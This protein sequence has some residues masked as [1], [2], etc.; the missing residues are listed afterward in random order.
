MTGCFEENRLQ[1]SNG[2]IYARDDVSFV[3][4]GPSRQMIRGRFFHISQ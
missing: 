3:Q 2:T 1:G 4:G